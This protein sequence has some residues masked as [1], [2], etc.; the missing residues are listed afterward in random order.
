MTGL[1]HQRFG[2]IPT[3]FI[4]SEAKKISSLPLQSAAVHGHDTRHSILVSVGNSDGGKV[5]IWGSCGVQP[6]NDRAIDGASVVRFRQLAETALF[7]RRVHE[8]LGGRSSRNLKTGQESLFL[9][10]RPPHL[11][12]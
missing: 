1:I 12:R 7:P 8:G 2:W 10:P 5:A 9:S 3:F 4:T 6:G 11:V